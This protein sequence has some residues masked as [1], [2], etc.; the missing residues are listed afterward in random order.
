MAALLREGADAS[1]IGP[2]ALKQ[3]LDDGV[4]CPKCR[5][6]LAPYCPEAGP[7]HLLKHRDG[8]WRC[9][10]HHAL[11]CYQCGLCAYPVGPA[12]YF[13]R[14]CDSVLVDCRFCTPERFIRPVRS[15]GRCCSRCQLPRSRPFLSMRTE[16]EPPS[17]L[18]CSNIYGCPV[19]ADLFISTYPPGRHD[20]CAICQHQELPLLEVRTR[21][22]HVDACVFCRKLLGFRNGRPL[23]PLATPSL[24]N[25]CL[26]GQSFAATAALASAPQSFDA[27]ERI[28]SALLASRND[29]EAFGI[30]FDTLSPDDRQRMPSHI[31]DFADRVRRPAVRRVL[32][33]RLERLIAHYDRQFGCRGSS[34]KAVPHIPPKNMSAEPPAPPD[35]G[36]RETVEEVLSSERVSC[37]RTNADFERWV[38]A[39]VELGI[40]YDRFDA[41]LGIPSAEPARDRFLQNLRDYARALY[42]QMTG[43][44]E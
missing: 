6:H 37:L 8:R 10:V 9:D 36:A 5:V 23:P 35:P 27:A 25:C 3:F 39:V 18:F 31:R 20:T 14:R 1:G 12:E 11:E 26:C 30:L 17:A 38:A 19:G 13:C 21:S 42:R 16:D 28:G 24:G 15:A 40:D 4:A 43:G 2:H 29:D 7:R 32:Y 34:S 33:P 41:A 22:M 44:R